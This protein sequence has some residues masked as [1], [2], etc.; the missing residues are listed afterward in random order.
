MNKP[1]WR[2]KMSKYSRQLKLYYDIVVKEL[3]DGES[4]KYICETNDL[5]YF[6]FYKKIKKENPDVLKRDWTSNSKKKRYSEV[7]KIKLDEAVIIDMYKNQKISARKIADNFNVVQNT[8]LRILRE[9]KVPKNDQSNYWTEEMKEHQ[10]T[11]CYDAKIGIHSQGDGA[12]RFTKPE[13]DFTA[14][15]CENNI[16][17]ERQYQIS[18]G[19]HRYDFKIDGTS[20]LVEIDG[21]F[22]HNKPEQKEKDS[23]FEKDAKNEGFTVLRFSDKVINSTKSRC[24]EELFN[25]VQKEKHGELAKSK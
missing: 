19:T 5:N 6:A 8:I 17:Y 14:W 25:Y 4:L 23:R 9:N 13:R 11:L 10:R 7:Q 21:E 1:I 15:C 16:K 18:K 24:F 22:W 2:K 12:Y 20:V 3:Q